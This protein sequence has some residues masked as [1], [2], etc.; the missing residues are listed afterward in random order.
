MNRINEKNLEK[1]HNRIENPVQK[2]VDKVVIKCFEELINGANEV[3]KKES[4]CRAKKDDI[5]H[6]L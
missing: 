1:K 6:L 4:G 5:R 3:L 2:G